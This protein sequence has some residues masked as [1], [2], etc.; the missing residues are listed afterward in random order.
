VDAGPRLKQHPE[1]YA[2]YSFGDFYR[3]WGPSGDWGINKSHRIN[4]SYASD[5]GVLI[6]VTVNDARNT[7]TCGRKEQQ[8]PSL[9]AE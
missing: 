3:D 1:K 6:Q 8:N 9:R 5:S 4:C 2:N 7:P